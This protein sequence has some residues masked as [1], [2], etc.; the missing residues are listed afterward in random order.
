MLVFFVVEVVGGIWAG[1]LAIISDAA[2]LLADVSVSAPYSVLY[3]HVPVPPPRVLSRPVASQSLAR[4]VSCIDR[5]RF[6]FFGVFQVQDFV[7][8]VGVLCVLFFCVFF[9]F[10]RFLFVLGG[11]GVEVVLPNDMTVHLGRPDPT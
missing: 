3:P 6:S 5:K 11:A 7:I 8:S 10:L 1:S 9:F 2:H 4:V